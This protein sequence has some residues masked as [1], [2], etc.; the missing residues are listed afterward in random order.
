MLTLINAFHSQKE[1]SNTRRQLIV[2]LTVIEEFGKGK[3]QKVNIE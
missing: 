3:W 2:Q 1:A